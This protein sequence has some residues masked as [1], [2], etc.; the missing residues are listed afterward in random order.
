MTVVFITSLHF[1]T[2]GEVSIMA[3]SFFILD[4]ILPKDVYTS[5]K[6]ISSKPYPIRRAFGQYNICLGKK[7]GTRLPSMAKQTDL[8]LPILNQIL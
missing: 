3:E 6:R 7:T 8:C 2:T 1:P 5:G 4:S